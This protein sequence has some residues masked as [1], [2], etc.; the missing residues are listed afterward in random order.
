M[1]DKEYLKKF[2]EECSKS[3]PEESDEKFIGWENLIYILVGYSLRLLLPE[4]KKWMKLGA[5]TIAIK[6]LEIKKKLVDYAKER[7]L[8][9]P[10][11][12]IAAEVIADKI[13]RENLD[14]IIKALEAEKENK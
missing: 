4:L 8:D 11:A 5:E 9:F 3:M 13:D 12:E 6:R 10:Q 14:K 7:E 2:V 1:S